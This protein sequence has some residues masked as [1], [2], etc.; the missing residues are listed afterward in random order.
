VLKVNSTVLAF[1]ATHAGITVNKFSTHIFSLHF[2]SY[3][4]D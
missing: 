2:Y 4:K 1:A 3:F